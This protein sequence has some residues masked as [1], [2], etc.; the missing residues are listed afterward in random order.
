M[1]PQ[2]IKVFAGFSKL[3]GKIV[4]DDIDSS[5]GFLRYD[6]PATVYSEL[7]DLY[8]RALLEDAGSE[9]D[10]PGRLAGQ[11]NIEEKILIGVQL[12]VLISRAKF[13]KQ[14]LLAFYLFMTNLGVASEAID[15][16]YQL[17]TSEFDDSKEKETSDQPLESLTLSGAKPAD[18]IFEGISQGYSVAA[19][20]FQNLILI[21]NIGS[22]PIIAR[23][24]QIDP[25]E[26]CRLF[27]GQRILLVDVVLDHQDLIFYFNSK[28]NVSSTKLYLAFT[29]AGSPYI[30]KSQ[31]RESVLEIVF[32]LNVVIRALKKTRARVAGQDLVPGG[33]LE[34]SL[35]DRLSFPNKTEVTLAEL[36]RRARELGG[37]FDLVTSKTEYLVS[38]DPN[39]LRERDILLSQGTTGRL[40]LRIHCDYEAKTGEVEVIE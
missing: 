9:R 8:Q 14:Q 32:G 23:G 38:N 37:S 7:R 3:D 28:K 2:L 31:T 24:R 1:L 12:Y 17:N 10:G 30:E 6:Y 25:G 29:P 21:K 36:R 39:K 11:L 15:I 22:E 18:V 40:L 34:A 20:R 4:E 16:V 5:L 35:S 26:F 19:F 27:D 33:E 13:Q